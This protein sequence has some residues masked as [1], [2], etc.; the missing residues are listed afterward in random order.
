MKVILAKDSKLKKVFAHAVPCKWPDN[1]GHAV[2][3]I[4][5]DILWLGHKRIILKSDNELAVLKLPKDGQ[6]GAG[7]GRTGS[8]V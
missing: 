8:Q 1:D 5:G 4:A 3:R 6:A 2:P 7:D